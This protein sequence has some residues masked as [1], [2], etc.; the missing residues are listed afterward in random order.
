MSGTRIESIDPATHAIA[1]F[2]IPTAKSVPR[3]LALARPFMG[4]VQVN[5]RAGPKAA[6]GASSSGAFSQVAR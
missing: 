3:T 6:D 5:S 4:A 1:E 2:V